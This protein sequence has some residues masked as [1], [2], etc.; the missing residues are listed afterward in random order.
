MNSVLKFPVSVFEIT[1][2]TKGA[3]IFFYSSKLKFIF[4]NQGW[5]MISFPPL[6]P[7]L[8]FGYLVNSLLNKS[9]SWGLNCITH[10]VPALDWA[11]SKLFP[12]KASFYSHFWRAENQSAFRG[13]GIRSTTSQ[14]QLHGLPSWWSRVPSTQ[15]CRR[16]WAL[17]A[18][19][20]LIFSRA[21]NQPV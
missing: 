12:R 20:S 16:L 13:W 1:C 15:E 19:C 17:S 10:C 6:W 11:Q 4:S 3:L 5:L 7:S 9:W 18:R 8:L 14:H 21:Q 2:G